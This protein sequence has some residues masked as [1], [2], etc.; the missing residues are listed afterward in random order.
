M[1][2]FQEPFNLNSSQ[3]EIRINNEA[4]EANTE[5]E[6]LFKC[7]QCPK[8]Y[9]K[10]SGVID[11]VRRAH[12][13][14][15]KYYQCEECGKLFYHTKALKDHVARDHLK[16]FSECEEIFKCDKCGKCYTSADSLNLHMKFIC[17]SAVQAHYS[18][19]Q[20]VK[21]KPDAINETPEEIAEKKSKEQKVNE[22]LNQ[23]K[24]KLC[25]QKMIRAI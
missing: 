1:T 19:V 16:D 12:T 24:G 25:F 11:H 20:S 13:H 10:R 17:K 21:R 7:D 4:F 9:H 22:R 14:R 23:T 8:R 5:D 15:S 3:D 6:K 2:S 18:T